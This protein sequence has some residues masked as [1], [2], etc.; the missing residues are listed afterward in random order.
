MLW[1]L[2]STIASFVG[3]VVALYISWFTVG[4]LGLAIEG[5]NE[6][7]V[8]SV[9]FLALMSLLLTPALG[10]AQ[11]WLLKHYLPIAHW[12]G[13]I[14]AG[15]AIAAAITSGVG[16][17][18]G[19]S[20]DIA[21]PAIWAGTA[22]AQWFLL[23]RFSSKSIAWPIPGVAQIPLALNQPN[24]VNFNSPFGILAYSVVTAILIVWIL[25]GSS[26][27]VELRPVE[28]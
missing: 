6:G 19:D 27:P 12:F 10:A 23:R 9:V 22:I 7:P 21:L 28:R 3:G 8:G 4:Q 5:T 1:W 15:G 18:G 26:R 17:S 24:L 2:V 20:L 25:R 16:L 14:L 11:G 13:A